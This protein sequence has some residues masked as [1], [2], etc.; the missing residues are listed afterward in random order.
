MAG[1][2]CEGQR[3]VTVKRSGSRGQFVRRHRLLPSASAFPTIR[4]NMT[5]NEKDEADRRSSV[6]LVVGQRGRN[7]ADSW[8]RL[9]FTYGRCHEALMV[10]AVAM[11]IGETAIRE[12]RVDSSFTSCCAPR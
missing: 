12:I 7:V 10:M 1:V 4:R 5:M 6:K 2:R 11:T 8:G 9:R 3:L